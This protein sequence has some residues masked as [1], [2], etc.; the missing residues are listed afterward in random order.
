MTPTR[1]PSAPRPSGPCVGASRASGGRKRAPARTAGASYSPLPC[2]VLAID[3]G[4][5]SGWA[6]LTPE[7]RWQLGV[8]GPDARH[9]ARLLVVAIATDAVVVH[10]LPL[11]VV[12]ERWAMRWRPAGAPRESWGQWLSALDE[13]GVPRRRIVRVNVGRWSARL[14]GGMALTTEQRQSRSVLVAKARFG[15]D[16]THDEAAALL[17]ALWG[18]RAGEVARVLPKP[19]RQAADKSK[20]GRT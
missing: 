20:G 17:M 16:V 8:L 3:P 15:L 19:K 4:T 7:G 5:T 9:A 6:V 1:L 14:L 2:V 18:S 11:V 12:A 13:A 10:G